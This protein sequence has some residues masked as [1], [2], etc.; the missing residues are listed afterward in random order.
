MKPT[1]IIFLTL[2]L[3]MLSSSS[4]AQFRYGVR[5]EVSL[6]NPSFYSADLDIQLKQAPVLLF[7][8]GGE[9]G[10]PVNNLSVEGSMLYGY[11]TVSLKGAGATGDLQFKTHYI[12]V[13]LTAKMRFDISEYAKPVISVGPVFKMYV[14]EEDRRGAT[15]FDKFNKNEF[16]AGIIAGAGVEVIN[17]I[18]VGVNYRYLL[19]G[20]NR[21]LTDENNSQKG[22]F[23]VSASV[24]F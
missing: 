10:L 18:T 5:G 8:V 1:K 24:Y 3:A 21:R 15:I 19:S 23:T 6:N 22:L 4:F 17:M 11:E 13:P 16:L 9:L 2:V 12:D 7:G 14:S 20:E